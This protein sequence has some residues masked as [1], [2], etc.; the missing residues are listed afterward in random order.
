MLPDE[1]DAP[2][3]GIRELEFENDRPVAAVSVL[4]NRKASASKR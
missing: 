3:E 2:K 4:K 1:I